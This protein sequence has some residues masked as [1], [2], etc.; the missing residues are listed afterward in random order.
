VAHKT[1]NERIVP[2]QIQ[3]PLIILDPGAGL[4][5]H[6]S[7]DGLR[8]GLGEVILGHD[9]AVEKRVVLRWPRNTF[10]PGR[11]VKVRVR[12]DD[13]K[14]MAREIPGSVSG[15]TLNQTG[16]DGQSAGGQAGV[17]QKLAA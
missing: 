13:G 15:A 6:G 9:F 12:V 10:R 17:F 16:A 1:D 11:I 4:D 3:N 2:R 7:G 8:H 14:S 5:H